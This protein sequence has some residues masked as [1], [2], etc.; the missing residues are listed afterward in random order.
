[1]KTIIWKEIDNIKIITGFDK[2]LVDGAKTRKNIKEKL[3]KMDE[4]SAVK[5]AS[6][7]HQQAILAKKGKDIIASLFD[8]I[9]EKKRTLDEKLE[10]ISDS[11][12]EYFE[13]KE[14]E[15]SISKDEYENIKELFKEAKKEGKLLSLDLKKVDNNKGM[16]YFVKKDNKFKKIVITKIGDKIPK[17]AILSL[18]A[19][20]SLKYKED[21]RI[22]R[23]SKLDQ[24]DKDIEFSNE[25]KRLIGETLSRG[26]ELQFD[27]IK[28]I[29]AENQAMSE[30]KEKLDKFKI[31]YNQ[32]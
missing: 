28:K 17:T 9:K 15:K 6:F 32:A 20:D 31:D 10:S 26:I 18:E 27:G 8:D 14:G 16:H 30:G 2:R 7:D 1:M 5:K 23:V 13:T 25:K 11:L 22:D 21:E 3:S 12:V 24:K 19:A 4:Y 29:D